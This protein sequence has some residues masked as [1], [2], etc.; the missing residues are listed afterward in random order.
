MN[1]LTLGIAIGLVTFAIGI[2]VIQA[3][4]AHSPTPVPLPEPPEQVPGQTNGKPMLEMV[5]VLDTT[6]SMGGLIEGA[7]Q[8]IWGIVNE[9]MQSASHPAVRVGL[10]AY[11][12]HGDEYVTKVLPL[13]NDL[14]Q[15][16][17]TLMSYRAAGGGDTPEDVRRALAEGVHKAGWSPRAQGIAQIIFLVG[18]APPHNDYQDEPD[19]V[20]TTAAAVKAGMIVNTIQCGNL[21]ETQPAWQMIAQR[22]EGQYFAIAQDGGVQAIATPYDKEMAEKGAILGATYVAYGGGS[23]AAGAR[24]RAEASEK[25][26]AMESSVATSAPAPAAADRAVNK[27]VNSAAYAGDLLT[28]LENGS[29][30]L[31]AVKD[32]DLPDDLR[33]LDSEARKKE[34]EKRLA[35]RQR[36]RAE[37]LKLQKQR[38]EF[39]AAERK[40]QSGPQNGFDTAV[41]ESLKK[42]L[43]SK[44]IKY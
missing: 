9:V 11:R 34:I 2:G 42:Q 15:V 18:D 40:K 28:S 17:A 30:K 8:R 4:F 10:V 36:L 32:E 19:T 27:A 1:K 43:T 25:Q 24:Y 23:G 21:P 33:K 3:G 38:D 44:G 13:T 35:D 12:D 6:G 37:I 14:D 16:Y 20:T 7:K 5:F 41:A 29:L 39:I 31:D 22:G 26:A